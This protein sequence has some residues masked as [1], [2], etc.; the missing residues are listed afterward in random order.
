MRFAKSILASIIMLCL[1]VA[2]FAFNEF[3][4]SVALPSAIA[5]LGKP[6]LLAWAFSLYLVFAIR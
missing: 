4:V 3:F 2:L 1:G 5:E 6:W